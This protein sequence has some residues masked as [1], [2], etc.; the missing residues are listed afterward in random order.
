MEGALQGAPSASWA[1]TKKRT[2]KKTAGRKAGT[3]EGDVHADAEKNPAEVRKEVAELVKAYATEMARAVI[4]E[5]NKGQLAPVKYLFEVA[6][7]F[8]AAQDGMQATAEEDCLAK[9]LLER[10]NLAA[11]PDEKKEDEAGDTAGKASAAKT[12]EISGSEQEDVER[13]RSSTGKAEGEAED[14]GSV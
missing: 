6:N 1:M 14:E 12:E 9:I 8:P 5:G 10:L 3:K 13:R 2:K 11:K 4:G 7:I